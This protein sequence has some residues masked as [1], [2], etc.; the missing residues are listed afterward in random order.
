MHQLT[1][2][3]IDKIGQYGIIVAA[4]VIFAETGLLFGFFLPG[5]SL[6]VSIGLFANPNMDKHIPNLD[7]WT[8]NMVLIIAAIIGDQLGFFLGSR[9]SD[10]IWKWKDGRFYKRKHM[11][12][13]HDFYMK[14]GGLAII[15][16]HFIPVMRTFVPFAAGVAKMPYGKFVVWDL[17]GAPVWITSLV[18]LGYFVGNTPLG[19]HIEGVI[20]VVIFISLLPLIIGFIKRWTK[21]RKEA[22]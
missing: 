6:L 21:A 14:H 7:I 4:I 10:N 12:E 2:F 19:K 15:G 1:D 11:E 8:V 9:V 3:I 20:L 5:D 13:A 18:W 22:A 17:I 16:A